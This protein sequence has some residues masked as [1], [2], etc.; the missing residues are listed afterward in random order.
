MP[1]AKSPRTPKATTKPVVDNKILQMPENGSTNPQNG[2]S[3]SASLSSDLETAI[4]ARAYE[5]YAQRGY[6]EG[7]EAE[8]W[9]A[10]ERE[11]L[12]RRA[13]SA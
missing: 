3:R 10:A 6:V 5:L 4:R 1:R 11:V 9:L 7:F 12:A 8:D 2:S 13:H